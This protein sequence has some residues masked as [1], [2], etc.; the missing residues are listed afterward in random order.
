MWLDQWV[1]GQDQK[2][3]MWAWGWFMA[4]S[5]LGGWEVEVREQGFETETSGNG[6]Q[7]D[8]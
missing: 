3:G 2:P 6:L 5:A 4:S 1:S 7:Y 8:R